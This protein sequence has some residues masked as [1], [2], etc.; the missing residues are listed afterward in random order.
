MTMEPIDPNVRT[1]VSL[2]SRDLD[3]F[4][5]DVE[6]KFTALG[7]DLRSLRNEIR[8][9]LREG[10][11]QI[12]RYGTIIIAVIGVI[13]WIINA[14]I[15][16]SSREN[17]RTNSTVRDMAASNTTAINTLTQSSITV[18]KQLTEDHAARIAN[19]REIETQFDADSQLRNVQWAT[20]Q[21]RLNDFQNTFADQGAKWPHISGDPYFAP[22]ISNRNDGR[23]Q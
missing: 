8:E 5:T 10:R 2:L 15:N 21:R 20:I 12:W 11:P 16:A 14:Q 9:S 18:L 17:E 3:A 1:E 6:E 22:N 23:M 19:E 4:K 13:W 7:G